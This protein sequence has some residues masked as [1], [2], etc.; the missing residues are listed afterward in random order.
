MG[1]SHLIAPTVHGNTADLPMAL[2]SNIGQPSMETRVDHG[3]PG[4]LGAWLQ[5]RCRQGFDL[6]EVEHLCRRI[7]YQFD[8]IPMALRAQ[9]SRATLAALFAELARLGWVRT[10]GIVQI[11]RDP[12]HWLNL[13]TPDYLRVGPVYDQALWEAA[14]GRLR[15]RFV[16]V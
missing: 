13:L 11:A 8:G 6:P 5:A 3:K 10:V 4:G 9:L 15:P 12:E 16:Q 2:A 14:L 7:Y 1:E